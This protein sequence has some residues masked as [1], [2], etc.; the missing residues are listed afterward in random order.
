MLCTPKPLPTAQIN[1]LWGKPEGVIEFNNLPEVFSCVCICY[2]YQFNLANVHV[3]SCYIQDAD[4]VQENLTSS[5]GT[6]FKLS[7]IDV[8]GAFA[9]GCRRHG[10]PMILFDIDK[11]EG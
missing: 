1:E 2:R 8:N 9:A 7:S 5:K 11:G 10:V 3:L 6:K 4:E